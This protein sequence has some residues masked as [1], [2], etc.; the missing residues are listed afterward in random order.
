MVV[1]IGEDLLVPILLGR[2][3]LATV[4]AIV[5]VK[6]GRIIFEVS[7]ERVGFEID[8][9]MEDPFVCSCCLLGDRS[10]KETSTTQ[11]LGIS[12][13]LWLEQSRVGKR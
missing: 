9:I 13:G 8:N 3:F 1:D 10:V 7:D 6:N 5:D 4:W 11:C 2:P 12:R